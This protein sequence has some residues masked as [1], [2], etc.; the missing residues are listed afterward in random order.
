MRAHCQGCTERTVQ[1]N[2]HTRCERY[3]AYQAEREKIR[4]ARQRDHIAIS[5]LVDGAEKIKKEALRR[6]KS[7]GM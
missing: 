2:C 1:P 7:K 6:S 3:L 4:A 5:A